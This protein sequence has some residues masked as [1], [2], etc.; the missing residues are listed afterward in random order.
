MGMTATSYAMERDDGGRLRALLRVT[1]AVIGCLAVGWLAFSHALERHIADAARAAQPRLEFYR[2]VLSQKLEEFR[3]LPAVVGAD[4][5]IEALLAAPHEAQRVADANA[6][7]EAIR[8]DPAVAAIYIMDPAGMTLA[9]SNWREPTSFVGRS[10]AFRPYYQDAAAGRPGRFYG[11][12]ATTLE[13]GYFLSSPIVRDGVIVGIAVVKVALDELERDWQRSGDLLLV[14]DDTGVLLIASI[15]Q[16]LYRALRPLP[17]D[18]ARRLRSTRQ[19]ADAD[20]SPIVDAAGEPLPVFDRPKVVRLDRSA[21]GLERAARDGNLFLV[22]SLS[23]DPPG[24][25]LI[26]LTDLAEA[27]ARAFTNAVAAGFA[28]AFLISLVVYLLLRRRRLQERLASQ[29]A[30]REAA[31]AL[32]RRIAERT[33]ALTRANQALQDKLRARQEAE[34]MLTEARDAAVQGGKLAVLGQM[35]AGITHEIN[36]PLA[37]MTTLADNAVKFLDVPRPEAVRAN[38]EMISQLAQRMGRIVAQLKTFSRRD[39]VVL[40][41]VAVA[42]AVANAMLL[43][44]SRRRDVDARIT[45][46]HADPELAL[47]GDATRVEQVLV[48]LLMNACDAVE[49]RAQ[50]ELLLAT[51]RDGVHALIVLR[52]SGP[53]IDPDVMPHLFEAFFTTKPAGKGLGLGLALSRLIAESLGGRLSAANEP[54]GGARFELRLPLR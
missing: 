15:P 52:D 19:Y 46:E 47:L 9:S 43:A 37:A 45:V 34:R 35:A 33:E 42:E 38:L 10:Y 27:R 30:L 3:Y 17:E 32:E 54:D 21:L 20:F 5:R 18:V 25:R 24:W 23:V 2:G 36:Q 51:R 39:G 29:R 50:R 12:G 41:R 8:R 26:G 13:P 1:L 16:W 53:G 49:G 40:Q 44:D 6:Y 14:A 22:Q 48:N 28:C 7:L 4:L 31:E 11:V